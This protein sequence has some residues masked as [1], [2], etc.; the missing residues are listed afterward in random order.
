MNDDLTENGRSGK[1]PADPGAHRFCLVGRWQ[2]IRDEWL[3]AWMDS[4]RAI[5]TQPELEA[6]GH[7]S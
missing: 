6:E 3:Q 2:G 1:S 4:N 5:G 7:D